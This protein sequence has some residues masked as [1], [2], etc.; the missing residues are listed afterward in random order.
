MSA[1]FYIFWS[2]VGGPNF[3][4]YL[5]AHSG[6]LFMK[7]MLALGIS[8]ILQSPPCCAPTFHD[9]CTSA[10]LYSAEEFD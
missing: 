3:L 10:A 7:Q 5:F 9:K 1:L 2:T 4:C 6:N 8:K